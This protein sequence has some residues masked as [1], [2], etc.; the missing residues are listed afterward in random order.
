MMLGSL[1][2]SINQMIDTAFLGRVSIEDMGA[3]NLGGLFFLLLVLVGMG[4]TKG[5]QILIARKAGALEIDGIGVIVCGLLL[6]GT[7]LYT[8]ADCLA[9]HK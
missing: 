4:F 5:G 3:G 9:G 1:A 8:L 7:S 2:Q 6:G